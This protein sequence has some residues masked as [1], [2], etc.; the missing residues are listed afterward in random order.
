MPIK[1]VRNYPNDVKEF[2]KHQTIK[3]FEIQFDSLFKKHAD[4][5][6]FK[7]FAPKIIF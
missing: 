2:Q 5:E 1:I 4:I 6:K 7:V 3:P